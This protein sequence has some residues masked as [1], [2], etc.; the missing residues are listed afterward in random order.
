MGP[1]YA[2]SH[3]TFYFFPMSPS[4]FLYDIGVTFYSFYKRPHQVYTTF[5]VDVSH[6]VFYPC[7]A[8]ILAETTRYNINKQIW[9]I[10][11]CLTVQFWCI[12]S[13]CVNL[14]SKLLSCCH[15]NITATFSLQEG[16]ETDFGK[17][18][19][20]FMSLG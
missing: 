8:L 18:S 2:V 15:N 20:L 9:F 10:T 7:G 13:T 14:Y 19:A 16:Q 4:H 5:K 17:I 3:V 11:T 1:N 12:M 6:F